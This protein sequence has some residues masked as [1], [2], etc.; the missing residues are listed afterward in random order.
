MAFEALNQQATIVVANYNYI[1]SNLFL[2]ELKNNRIIEKYELHE[3]TFTNSN[4]PNDPLLLQQLRNVFPIKLKSSNTDIYFQFMPAP[5]FKLSIFKDNFILDDFTNLKEIAEDLI[6]PQTSVISAIGL[7]FSAEFNLGDIKLQLLN[8][9]VETIEDFD[10]NRTFE[11]VLPI[12]Y[13]NENLVATYT[14]TKIKGGDNTGEDR[15]Y[16]IS[17]NFHFNLRGLKTEEK[18]KKIKDV[19]NID[20]YNKFLDKCQRFLA[21]NDKK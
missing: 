20:Y 7:N 4:V 5:D 16:E 8:S 19:L 15:Y 12:E 13:K 21:L 3:E 10:K 18:V 11:F 14:I 17:V 2:K 1:N 6:D 9:K